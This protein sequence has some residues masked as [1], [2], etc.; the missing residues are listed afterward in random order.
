MLFRSGGRNEHSMVLN[1]QDTV[2]LLKKRI[3]REKLG[4]VKVSDILLK[5]HGQSL[6]DRKR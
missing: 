6:E 4:P 5:L 2:G 1:A 3:V